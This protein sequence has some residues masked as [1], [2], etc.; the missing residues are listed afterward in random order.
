MNKALHAAKQNFGAGGHKWQE[1]VKQMT[2]DYVSHDV[3]DYGC[4]KGTLRKALPFDITEYDPAIEAKAYPKRQHDIV[5]CT[6]VL[7]HIEPE[8][9]DA[10]LDD[11]SWLTHKAALLVIS[12]RKAKKSLPD[13]RNAHLIIKDSSWWIARISKRFK[14]VTKIKSKQADEIALICEVI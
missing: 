8:Y 4:G 2:L 9:I 13:G 5:V 1:V 14:T 12:T 11:I 7:E 6:D 3:L 10:V